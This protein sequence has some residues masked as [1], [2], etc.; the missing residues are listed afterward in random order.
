M[1]TT[2]RQKVA[3][4]GIAGLIAIAAVAGTL[5]P[6]VPAPVTIAL[7]P[8]PLPPGRTSLQALNPQPLPPG[9]AFEFLI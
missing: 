1:I 2:L 5:A 6:L 7:N 4:V 3:G 8:Q 9:I